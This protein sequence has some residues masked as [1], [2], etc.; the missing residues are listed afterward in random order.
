ML[1]ILQRA[2]L[3]S[4]LDTDMGGREPHL[5]A[6][7]R[8]L[9]YVCGTLDYGLQLYSSSI[10]SLV[11]CSDVIQEAVYLSHSSTEAE[12]HDAA[13]A[14]AETSWLRNHIR[15]LHSPLHSATIV[16]CDRSAIY[17]SS[18]LMQHQRTKHIEI[19]IHFVRDQI[20]TGQTSLSILRTPA[21]TRGGC[22]PNIWG[23]VPS[24]A[25]LTR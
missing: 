14:V 8:I 6:L 2:S 11:A 13:N 19:D 25:R 18:N 21:P 3:V 12:Y 15:E 9:R 16:Y 20:A 23:A 10:S 1:N 24:M 7:K 17:L 5:A 4:Y 22:M